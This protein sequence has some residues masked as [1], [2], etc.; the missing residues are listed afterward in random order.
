MPDLYRAFLVED[1]F[2]NQGME[3]MERVAQSPDIN[4]IEHVWDY[5]GRQMASLSSPPRL[6]H[7]LE[8][9]LILAWSSLSI[10]VSDYLISSIE[11]RCR[12]CIAV[13]GGHSLFELIF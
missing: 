7:E 2:E 3:R 1:Y 13:R 5:L 12:Q 6:L 8:Y 11:N 10:K 4:P 9:G